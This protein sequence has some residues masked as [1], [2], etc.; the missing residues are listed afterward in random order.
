MFDMFDSVQDLWW[1]H[2]IDVV[3]IEVRIIIMMVISTVVVD[4]AHD[5]VTIIEHVIVIAHS[6]CA[7]IT[8]ASVFPAIDD[9]ELQI[10]HHSI[11]SVDGRIHYYCHY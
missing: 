7:P 1:E 5:G 10:A 2:A 11:L 3:V 9:A 4:I 8:K 6:H